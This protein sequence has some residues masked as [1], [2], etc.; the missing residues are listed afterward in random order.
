[1][2]TEVSLTIQLAF[3][4]YWRQKKVES[5]PIHA[6][7]YC[8]YTCTYNKDDKPKPTVSVDKLSY[9][10]GRRAMS[11]RES[12]ATS[13]GRGGRNTSNPARCSASRRRPCL[14]NRLGTEQRQL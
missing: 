2:A 5:I 3:D 1:M 6:G 12:R 7:V 10:S 8:V 4:G 14:R 13:A 11:G 9:T